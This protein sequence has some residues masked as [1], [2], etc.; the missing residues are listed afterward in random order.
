M[1]NKKNA[2][3]LCSGGLDS[4]VT[5]YYVKNKLKYS[6]LIILFFN[7]GQRTIK[8]E[9][10]FSRKCAEDLNVEFKEIKLEELNKISTSI[11]N[12]NR[13]AKKISRE[14]LKNTRKESNKFY[15]PLRNTVFLVYAIALAESLFIKQKNIYEIFVGFKN[16]GNESYPDTTNKYV[17]EINNLIKITTNGNFIV[18]APLINKD[19]EDIINLGTKLGVKFTHTHSCYISNIPCGTCLSCMLRKEGFYWS[20][21]KDQTKYNS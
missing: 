8:S 10:K 4:V 16:E 12:T 3:I 9:R 18:K 21:I 7:Y 19:K 15:V 1:T 2:I 11:I 5:A 13:K 17:K 14:D 6:K 20:G